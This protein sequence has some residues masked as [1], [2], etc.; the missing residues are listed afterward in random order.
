MQLTTHADTTTHE[1]RGPQTQQ[2]DSD[3]KRTLAGRAHNPGSPVP[4]TSSDLEGPE[5]REVLKCVEVHLQKSSGKRAVSYPQC[6]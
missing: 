1:H 2:G 6:L 4:L 5:S 3:R